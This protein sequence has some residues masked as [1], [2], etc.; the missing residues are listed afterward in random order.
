MLVVDCEWCLTVRWVR[1]VIAVTKPGKYEVRHLLRKDGT[2]PPNVLRAR[3]YCSEQSLASF[4]H[5]PS[6][7]FCT[8]PGITVFFFS[9]FSSD[10]SVVP[11]S[12]P[13]IS[14][15]AS[16]HLR[17]VNNSSKMRT[18]IPDNTTT[19]KALTPNPKKLQSQTTTRH[20]TQH[21][22]PYKHKQTI[23]FLFFC[24]W[25]RCRRRCG[26]KSRRVPLITKEN[27]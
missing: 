19:N 23:F 6:S 16:N 26:R 1:V 11:P 22:T 7:V 10:S 17:F 5:L 27:I 24:N 4:P 15:V 12:T 13:S 25:L 2:S 3:M 14:S 8:M 9:G 20:T 21:T 18:K